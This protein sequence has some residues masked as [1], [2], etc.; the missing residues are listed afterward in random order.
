MFSYLPFSI[1][2]CI[3]LKA[4]QQALCT[5]SDRLNPILTR[6]R[7]FYWVLAH[8]ETIDLESVCIIKVILTY[9]IFSSAK[10]CKCIFNA[11][12]LGLSA[13]DEIKKKCSLS[14]SW[15]IF[16]DAMEGQGGNTWRVRKEN[17]V[18]FALYF[19][20]PVKSS[21]CRREW[22]RLSSDDQKA[23]AGNYHRCQN[24]SPSSPEWFVFFCCT[25]VFMLL[26]SFGKR[27]PSDVFC[28][29]KDSSTNTSLYAL[30]PQS[31]CLTTHIY[32]IF[33][34]ISYE[35]FKASKEGWLKEEN[36]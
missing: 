17:S 4:Y 2:A 7:F 5:S 34:L 11:I 32:Y 33:S 26:R 21:L 19:G 18:Y 35:P 28:S 10:N 31:D 24:V 30:F 23:D 3:C 12:I 15:W 29:G 6:P 8:K 9:G 14:R 13:E 25:A 16:T 22:D 27:N 1:K 36:M 20:S